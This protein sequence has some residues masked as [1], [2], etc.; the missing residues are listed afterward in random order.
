[1]TKMHIAPPVVKPPE[2]NRL[3]EAAAFVFAVS[4]L[5]G[6]VVIVAAIVVAISMF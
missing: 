3:R 1:M 4:G 2:R 5:A 6:V